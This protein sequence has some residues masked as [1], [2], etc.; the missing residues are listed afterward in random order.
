MRDNSAVGTVVR[1]DNTV[2]TGVGT[3]VQRARGKDGEFVVIRVTRAPHRKT[4]VVVELVG[5]AVASKWAAEVGSTLGYGS[6]DSSEGV[7]VAATGD[8]TGG[9]RTRE[10]L[11]RR[12]CD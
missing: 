7:L 11:D 9:P 12:R 1:K 10:K 6:L 8:S 2:G 3:S 4:F 5:V